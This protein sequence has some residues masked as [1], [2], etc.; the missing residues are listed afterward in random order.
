MLQTSWCFAT[1][2]N[3][4]QEW[5]I[6]PNPT[7]PIDTRGLEYMGF[8]VSRGKEMTGVKVQQLWLLADEPK[9]SNLL[10]GKSAVNYSFKSDET[11]EPYP[12]GPNMMF[13]NLKALSKE[14]TVAGELSNIFLGNT[15]ISKNLVLKD[16]IEHLK[17][18]AKEFINDK[19]VRTIYSAIAERE[20]QA[21]L[22]SREKALQEGREEGL[23]KGR[24][25]GHEMIRNMIK[26]G[27][28]I[29]AVADLTGLS[30]DYI[31]DIV[32]LGK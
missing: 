21:G 7:L 28:T 2:P 13:V 12:N 6:N 11:G 32:K 9:N 26:K 10:K 14:K 20:Y 1:L 17:V 16:I 3:D 5:Q 15:Q 4:F 29:E 30:Q 24:E 27:F 18:S 8:S 23:E 25:E 19:E 31:A 22:R